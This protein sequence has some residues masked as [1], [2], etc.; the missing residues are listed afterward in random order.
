M[1]T[2]FLYHSILG[3]TKRRFTVAAEYLPDTKQMKFGVALYSKK[4][5]F[6]R[7]RGRHIANRRCKMQKSSQIKKGNAGIKSVPEGATPGQIFREF[8][9]NIY[10][11]LTNKSS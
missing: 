4:D 3:K 8:C 1:N 11:L 2:H 10:L 7:A 6:T 9:E 5:T